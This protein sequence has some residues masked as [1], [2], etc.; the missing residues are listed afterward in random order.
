M[1]RKRESFLNDEDITAGVSGSANI[2][3]NIL[4]DDKRKGGRADTPIDNSPELLTIEQSNNKSIEQS[5]N[6]QNN[7]TNNHVIEHSITRT[8]KQSHSKSHEQST[9]QPNDKTIERERRAELISQ[10]TDLVFASVRIPRKYDEYLKD[11]VLAT[12]RGRRKNKT[13]K[14]DVVI[15]ALERFYVINPV[16]ANVESEDEL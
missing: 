10:S 6:K 5:N 13:T 14:Q 16:P 12:N 7:L 8:R 15:A 1:P 4:H 11:Y 9:D 2:I 3:A